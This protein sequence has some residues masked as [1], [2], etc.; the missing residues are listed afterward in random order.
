[1]TTVA[2]AAANAAAAAAAHGAIP[3]S[4]RSAVDPAAAQ[5]GDRRFREDDDQVSHLEEP[6]CARLECELFKNYKKRE[7]VCACQ[8]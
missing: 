2:A 1:M 7:S 5:I 4:P 3:L 8:T 6:H